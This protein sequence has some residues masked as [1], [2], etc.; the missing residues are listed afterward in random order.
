VSH[1]ALELAAVFGT[2][3]RTLAPA[4]QAPAPIDGEIALVNPVRA[5]WPVRLR[6]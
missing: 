1:A 3:L 5:R 2:L 4:G 6:P